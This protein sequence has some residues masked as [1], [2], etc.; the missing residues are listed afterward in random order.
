MTVSTTDL[1]ITWEKL[2][3][4]FILDEHPLQDID[5]PLLAAALRESLEI[6]GLILEGTLVASHLA[7]CVNFNDKLVIKTPDLFYATN[8]QPL[9][10]REIRR[11]YTPNLEGD[12]PAVVMEFLPD[13]PPSYQDEYSAK[14][15]YL[16]GK[17]HF[18]EQILQAPIYVIFQPAIGALTVYHLGSPAYP[19]YKKQ[20]P[21]ANKRYWIPGV[22]LF[23]GVWQG[24]KAERTG[25][26]L[27]WWDENGE[28]LLWGV[29]MVEKERQRGDRL[30]AQLR[31]AGIDPE[32]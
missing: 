26:W 32:A 3:A 18:Y 4:D 13:N 12:I 19:Y 17:W 7:I 22:G 5:Q 24:I 1:K 15:T 21:D 16:P 25:Y 9:P 28:M 23:L 30:M 31:V 29:E 6:A 8:V 11:S 20:Q 2:P 10:D 27:R 14:P